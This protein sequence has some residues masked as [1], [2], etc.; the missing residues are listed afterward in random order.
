[1]RTVFLFLPAFSLFCIPKPPEKILFSNRNPP[2]GA[3]PCL[4]VTAFFRIRK[5]EKKDI[6]FAEGNAPRAPRP[7]L[8]FCPAPL[9]IVCGCGAKYSHRSIRAYPCKNRTYIFV[10]TKKTKRRHKS[11]PPPLISSFFIFVSGFIT[12]FW[13]YISYM[14]KCIFLFPNI[15][16]C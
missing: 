10:R 9:Q 8:F 15:N 13:N 14:Y 4:P 1:M 16:K 12:S 2:A 11:A 3:A 7:S 5:C 6:L